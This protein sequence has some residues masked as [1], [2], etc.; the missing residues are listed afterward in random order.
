MKKAIAVLLLIAMMLTLASCQSKNK[1]VKEL[2]I[3]GLD[4]RLGKISTRV[5]ERHGLDRKGTLK[6]IIH[7]KEDLE[8]LLKEN[9][10]WGDY[11]VENPFIQG[12]Y[13][14]MGKDIK[15]IPQ[16]FHGYFTIVDRGAGNLVDLSGEVTQ[17]FI[18]AVYDAGHRVMYYMEVNN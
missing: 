6:M 10:R 15:F 14:K 3:L 1:G 7:F 9:D 13:E 18:F 12:V 16:I 2:T 4:P 11:P 17:S 5:D 8:P